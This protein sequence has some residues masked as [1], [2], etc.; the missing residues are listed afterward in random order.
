M[1]TGKIAKFNVEQD[2]VKK[3]VFIAREDLNSAQ[4]SFASKN[5]KWTT[6]QAYYAFFHAVRS[7]L[8][9]R[10]LR[11]K[12]HRCLLLAL[13]VLYI[14]RDL[15]PPEYYDKF[16]VAMELRESADYRSKYTRKDAQRVINN[17]AR[18]IDIADSII[19]SQKMDKK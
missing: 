1:E 12:S 3:E 6:I 10:K 7:L 17:A 9:L 11:E 14:D 15:V 5:Y 4:I 13:K 19:K 16:A 8:F 18:M 2:M